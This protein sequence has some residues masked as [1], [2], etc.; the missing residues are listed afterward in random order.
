VA[1]R[2]DGVRIETVP[3][4]HSWRGPDARRAHGEWLVGMKEKFR[5]ERE[6]LKEAC[7][8]YAGGNFI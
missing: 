1:G 5:R 2:G 6:R 4:A 7:L 8:P 3:P